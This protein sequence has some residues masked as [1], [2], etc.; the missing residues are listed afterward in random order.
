[1]CGGRTGPKMKAAFFFFF[2]PACISQ[3]G[4]LY[5]DDKHSSSVSDQNC[6]VFFVTAHSHWWRALIHD[7]CSLKPQLLEAP[8]HRIS[9]VS[10]MGKRA[11]GTTHAFF[12]ASAKDRHT[13]LLLSFIGQSKSYSQN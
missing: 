4:T 2:S 13:S 3:D 6:A 7:T 1:M 12:S 11:W 10:V 5:S 9:Q 8:A